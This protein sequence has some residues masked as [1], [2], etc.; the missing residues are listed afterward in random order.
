MERYGDVITRRH[1]PQV[2]RAVLQYLLQYLRKQRAWSCSGWSKQAPRREW[3]R[4][5]RQTR[6]SGSQAGHQ[7]D[8]DQSCS[9]DR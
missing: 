8:R 7:C 6:E 2:F 5:A 9:H 3:A 1:R 4:F